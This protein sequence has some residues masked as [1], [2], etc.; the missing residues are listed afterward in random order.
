V[1]DFNEVNNAVLDAERAALDS[2]G[3]AAS[4]EAR[5]CDEASTAL[6]CALQLSPKGAM[7]VHQD[8][9]TGALSRDVDGLFLAAHYVLG[10]RTFRTVRAARAVLAAGWE[11]EVAPHIRVL[12]ELQ[13]HQRVIDEDLSGREALRWLKG[14][15]GHGITAKVAALGVKELYV[16]LL[17]SVPLI[18]LD[19]LYFGAGVDPGSAVH[20]P[21]YCG[22]PRCDPGPLPVSLGLFF[23][24]PAAALVTMGVGLRRRRDSRR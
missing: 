9:R 20:R 12:L 11:P 19:A 8:M 18:A 15:A 17:W 3:E 13:A 7:G 1:E 22:E 23:L 24:P 14:K 16:R 21:I 10:V 2:F 4:T 5:L 6:L